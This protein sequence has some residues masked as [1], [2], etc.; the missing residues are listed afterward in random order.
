MVDIVGGPVKAASASAGT[1]KVHS[2]VLLRDFA[3][4]GNSP[5][6]LRHVCITH[7]LEHESR[8]GSHCI[9]AK[10]VRVCELG[11]V[12]EPSDCILVA[13]GGRA[14]LPI[15]IHWHRPSRHVGTGHGLAEAGAGEA[16]RAPRAAAAAG[17]PVREA[18]AGGLPGGGQAHERL[19]VLAH[20][21]REHGVALALGHRD[22]GLRVHGEALAAAQGLQQ[23]RDLVARWHRIVRRPFHQKQGCK[24]RPVRLLKDSRCIHREVMLAFGCPL[25]QSSP[26]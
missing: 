5:R 14:H 4:D 2:L 11:K 23:V 3:N 10:F 1:P 20:A 16:A 21:R 22:P 24:S 6:I 26:P 8:D 18:L 9:L 13:I 25:E 19:H 15:F 17:G 12:D 7:V